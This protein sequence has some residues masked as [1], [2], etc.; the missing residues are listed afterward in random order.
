MN[1][2]RL[3]SLTNFRVVS[4]AHII[5]LDEVKDFLASNIDNDAIL[6]LRSDFGD[7]LG[8]DT[9]SGELLGGI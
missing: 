1:D 2:R 7:A 4:L 6:A 9:C 5:V 3:G 8:A